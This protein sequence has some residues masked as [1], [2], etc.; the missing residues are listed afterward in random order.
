MNAQDSL[1]SAGI[2]AFLD[3]DIDDIPVLVDGTPK[4]STLTLNRHTFIK[5]PI[6]AA[7]PQALL[8]SPG[9][10]RPEGCPPF[11]DGFV[12]DGD[13]TFSKQIFDVAKTERKSVIQP[14]GIGDDV[15]WKTISAISEFLFHTDI[16]AES[17]AT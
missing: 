11:A 8:D 7:R 15:R 16:V 1:S 2:F 12:G 5:K 3:K 6:I 13:S 9:I 17:W 10:V 4:I 14:H